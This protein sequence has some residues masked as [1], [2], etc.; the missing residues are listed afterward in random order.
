MTKDNAKLVDHFIF[1][2]KSTESQIE[3]PQTFMRKIGVKFNDRWIPFIMDHP[4]LFEPSEFAVS[5]RKLNIYSRLE[6]EFDFKWL[7]PQNEYMK[8]HE[9]REYMICEER[10]F[11]MKPITGPIPQHIIKLIEESTFNVA[12]NGGVTDQ[13]N[14]MHRFETAVFF[15][16]AINSP[17]HHLKSDEIV[18]SLMVESSDDRYNSIPF[19]TETYHHPAPRYELDQDD[20]CVITEMMKVLSFDDGD[21][22]GTIDIRSSSAVYISCNGGIDANEAGPPGKYEQAAYAQLVAENCSDIQCLLTFGMLTKLKESKEIDI[23][24]VQTK[25]SGPDDSELSGNDGGSDLPFF[26]SRTTPVFGTFRSLD[27]YFSTRSKP[28]ARRFTFGNA[29]QRVLA[30]M[31]KKQSVEPSNDHNE[32]TSPI[33]LSQTSAL[34]SSPTALTGT[35]TTSPSVEDQQTG[36][37]EKM[38]QVPD[39]LPD[40]GD[41]S[42][43]GPGGGV[44]AIRSASDIVNNGLLSSYGAEG[45]GYDGGTIYLCAADAVINRGE[46][47]CI[48]NGR[49]IVECR[50][51]VNE[52]VI[53]PG[54][55]IL[56]TDG[57]VQREIEMVRMPW[58]CGTIKE[59]E[60]VVERHRGHRKTGNMDTE[61]YHPQNLLDKKGIEYGFE[62]LETRYMGKEPAVGDWIIFKL[63]SAVVVIPTAISIRT[64]LGERSPKCMQL[65]LS[66]DGRKFKKYAKIQDID[67]D[68]KE[69]YYI[70]KDVSLSN[71]QIWMKKY[72]YLKVKITSN[73]GG[74][75]NY[76]H[77]F[78]LFGLACDS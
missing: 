76:F 21:G 69:Q 1:S 77:S 25:S 2:L 63:E 72:K 18:I 34:D 68:E 29:K 67:K 28:R 7:W 38:Q 61:K 23:Q 6:R 9:L 71:A 40:S 13:Q 60:L 36:R 51:F 53:I 45:G 27:K 19:W 17:V 78:S 4:M 75:F 46:I 57:T 58:E 54:P 5:N 59:I 12:V 22:T 56:I 42:A 65:S 47:K 8:I 52:G 39:P 41:L 10:H 35:S 37:N 14:E 11:Q 66:V 20:D 55:E 70:L 3:D 24:D 74:D 43:T 64:S 44:I 48:P 15:R 26:S 16:I 33:T 62:S 49:I 50:Q 32:R 73:W 30:K 31:T